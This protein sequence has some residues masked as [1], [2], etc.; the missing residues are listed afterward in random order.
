MNQTR[1]PLFWVIV[2]DGSSDGTSGLVARTNGPVKLIWLRLENK[3]PSIDRYFHVVSSGISR[4]VIECNRT[5]SHPSFISVVDADVSI[6]P[7]YFEEVLQTLESCNQVGIASGVMFESEKAGFRPLVDSWGRYSISGAAV[8]YR[9]DC[10]EE[11]GGYPRTVA[12]DGVVLCKAITRGWIPSVTSKTRFFH[13]R[14]ESSRKRRLSLGRHNYSLG[15][16]PLTALLTAIHS[17]MVG[18]NRL[19][20]PAFWVGYTA[21]SLSRIPRV[22]DPEILEMN[23]RRSIQAILRQMRGPE[24]FTRNRKA[25]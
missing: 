14:S 20:G 3:R 8:V 17:M 13:L 19:G 4:G 21:A 24:I 25:R 15:Y 10:L 18:P 6:A 7:N 2:D 1:K 16:H 5:G 22:S 12:S 9:L 11:I 23:G